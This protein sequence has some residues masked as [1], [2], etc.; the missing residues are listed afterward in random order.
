VNAPEVILINA[1]AYKIK[2]WHYERTKYPRLGLGYLAAY[3]EQQQVKCKVIDAKFEGLEFIKVLSIVKK[4]NPLL[5]GITAMTPEIIDA[6]RLAE[7]I[8][9]DIPEISIVI[10]GAHAYA[11]PVE[12]LKE[13]DCFDFLIY[14]EGE[15]SL[16]DLVLALRKKK[17]LKDIDGLVYRENEKIIANKPRDLL[18]DLDE[19]PFPAWHLFPISEVYPIMASRGCPFRCVFCMRTSGNKIRNRRPEK[20]IEEMCLVYD[21]YKAKRFYFYDETF[22]IDSNQ[23]YRFLDLIIQKG[24]HKKVTW[25]VQT[26]VD[27]VDLNLLKKMK[28]AGCTWIGFGI[29]SGNEEI[30]KLIHKNITLEQAS[31]AIS[32]AKKAGLKTQSFFILGHPFDTKKTMKDTIDFA[33][34]LN[35]DTLAL[36]IMVPYPGTKVA[37]M[38]EKGDGNYRLLSKNWADYNKQIGNAL[39]MRDVSRKELERLQLRGYVKFYIHNFNVFKI[40]QI[41]RFTNFNTIFNWFVKIIFR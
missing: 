21:K 22:G 23:A 40:I 18:K 6:V 10:G 15:I 13:F 5:V 1:P 28:E 34:K 4:Q 17:A 12:T 20:I 37:E 32:L 39:E 26:R 35:T 14:G 16:Y 3:L 8:K 2:E 7:S 25:D 9:K 41:F 36:G 19:L 11:L 24:L 30:L 27:M 33:V 38:A 29:E 31:R